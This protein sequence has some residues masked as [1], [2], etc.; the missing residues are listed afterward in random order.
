MNI[1]YL[2]I[3]ASLIKHIAT[4]ENSYKVT[5]TIVDFAKNLNVKT[6]AEYVENEDIFNITKELGVDFSQGYYFSPP[7]SSPQLENC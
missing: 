4:N 2:K 3:D 5:K 6:I 7:I 1:D